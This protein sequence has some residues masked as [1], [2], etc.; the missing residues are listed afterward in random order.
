MLLILF[1][2]VLLQRIG[3]IDLLLVLLVIGTPRGL[4]VGTLVDRVMA[5][6]IIAKLVILGGVIMLMLRLVRVIVLVVRCV[7]MRTHV[8]VRVGMRGERY[9]MAVEERILVRQLVL[10]VPRIV[11][12][13]GI[14]LKAN[15]F[16]QQ[17]DVEI[18]LGQKRKAVM[19]RGQQQ[20]V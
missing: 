9:M 10:A 16:R 12:G 7:M 4:L 11:Q 13:R 2:G 14:I 18:V 1:I 8:R 20:R 15:R 17:T 19:Y 6:V 3:V 5:V